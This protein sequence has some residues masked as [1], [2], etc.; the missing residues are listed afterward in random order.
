MGRTREF[1]EETVLTEAAKVFAKNGYAGTSISQLVKATG[2]L[3]GSLY[4]A[5]YSKAGL[6]RT[7]F[8]YV[9]ECDAS[10]EEGL[11]DLLIVA[12]L[13]RSADDKEVNKLATNVIA[14]LEKKNK[15]PI[16]TII[17]KRI[18]LRGNLIKREEK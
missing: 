5:Y 15:I 16:E 8:N 14:E 2:L 12:L 18:M 17:A 7:C 1:N 13:E 3:R 4:S 9:A 6:F 11:I 10:S